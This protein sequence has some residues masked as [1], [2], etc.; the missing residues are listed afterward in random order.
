MILNDM[1]GVIIQAR[2]GSTRLPGK[3]LLQ[4][5]GR[6]LL[7]HVIGRLDNIQNKVQ[8]VI[9]TSTE[10]QDDVIANYCDSH[11]ISFF[12][13]S[14]KDVLGRYYE[15]SKKYEFNHIVRLTADNPFTDILEL[16]CLINSHIEEDNDYTHSFGGLPIGVGAE[17]FSFNALEKSFYEGHEPNHREHVNEYIQEHPDIF[18]IGELK[19]P[20]S[21]NY[22]SLRLT[23]DTKEDYLNACHIAEKHL[24]GWVSTEEAINICLHSV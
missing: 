17:I 3:V 2:M 21:K 14:K 9:A 19:V 15:C 6:P 20:E 24:G 1:I 7:E 5:A 4:I 13:G 18:K 8:V 22:P 11:F 23:V 16:E 12:R 10:K